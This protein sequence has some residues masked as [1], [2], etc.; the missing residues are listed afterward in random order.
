[1]PVAVVLLTPLFLLKQVLYGFT[2]ALCC[3]LQG[4]RCWRWSQGLGGKI[5]LHT[6]R[7]LT[8]RC[9]PCSRHP[10]TVGAATSGTGMTCAAGTSAAEAA[11]RQVRKHV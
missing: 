6:P 2:Q 8:G 5:P 7:W 1:M 9:R 3:C 11:A 10:V 4:W